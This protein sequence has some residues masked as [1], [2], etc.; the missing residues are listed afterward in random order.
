MSKGIHPFVPM[1][2]MMANVAALD[3]TIIVTTSP[4]RKNS[5]NDA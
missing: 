3:C 4:T 2:S 5:S 1:M